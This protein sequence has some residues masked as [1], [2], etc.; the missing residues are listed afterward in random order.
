MSGTEQR[1]TTVERLAD[2]LHAFRDTPLPPAVVHEGKRAVLNILGASVGAMETAPIRLLRGWVR[3]DGAGGSRP[4]VWTT[5]RTTPDRAALVNAAAMH[6]LDFNDTHIPTH[7]HATAPAAAAALA[8]AGDGIDAA[9]WLQAVVLGMEAHYFYSR[10]LMP[11]HFRRGFH[12]TAT[13]GAV[14]AAATAAH[15][16]DL[17]RA[18]T[19]HAL[20]T[21]MLTGGGLR[22][23]LTTMSNAYGVGNGARTGVCAATLAARGFESTWSAFDGPDGVRGAMSTVDD[24]TVEDVLSSLGQRWTVLENSYKRYPTE[25]ITQATVEGV[26]RLRAEADVTAVEGLTGFEV[27]TAPLV[28]E[29]VET[30]SRRGAPRDVLTRTFDTRFCAAMAWLRGAF[31]PSCMDPDPGTEAR[32]LAIRSASVVRAGEGFG[33]EQAR[34]VA[35]LRDGRSLE[36]FVD[37]YRGSAATPMTDADLEA[38]L[39]DAGGLGHDEADAVVAAVWAL[40]EGGPIGRL[41][42]AVTG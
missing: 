33:V 30:R 22:E 40:D 19:A 21:A 5:D 32:A 3:G 41:V 42:G 26:L 28:A 9:T 34:V 27:T 25:T 35:Q 16:L 6:V 10:A 2:F 12:V 17:D 8:L 37:G 29:V 11:S 31:D 39:R 4:V 38:K 18:A 1:P 13:G 23:G 15:V 36:T 14:A 7:A 24:A 20:A